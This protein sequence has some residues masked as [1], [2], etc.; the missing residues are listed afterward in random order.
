MNTNARMA[1]KALGMPKEDVAE[2]RLHAEG[3]A[4]DTWVVVLARRVKGWGPRGS[5]HLFPVQHSG[6]VGYE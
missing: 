1:R 3:N 5:E 4:V 2:L 6:V